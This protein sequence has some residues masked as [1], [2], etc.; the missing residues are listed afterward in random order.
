MSRANVT[1]WLMS[2]NIK[3]GTF[4]V[5]FSETQLGCLAVSYRKNARVEHILVNAHSEGYSLRLADKDEL[6]FNTFPE[7]ILQVTLLTYVYPNLPKTQLFLLHDD[8]DEPG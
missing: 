6:T 2:E 5:R 7:L 4:I 1:Q 3:A 8:Q